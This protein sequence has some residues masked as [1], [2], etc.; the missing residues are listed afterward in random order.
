MIF[1]R[2]VAKL[3]AQDWVAI[4]I[5]LAIVIIGVF[6]G[7][8]AANWNQSRAEKREAERLLGELKP[9]LHNFVNYFDTAKPYYETTR[10]YADVAFGGWRRDP[11]VSDKQFVIAAYQASQIYVLGLNG[12]SWTAIFGSERLPNIDDGEV[13]DELASLMTLNYQSIEAEL[14]TVYREHVRQV[15]PE[16][17]QDAIR[18]HCGDRPIPNQPLNVQLPASCDLDLQPARFAAAAAELRTRPELAGDL[19]WHQSS[20]AGFLADMGAVEALTR[21]LL[22]RIE[23]KSA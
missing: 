16:D 21:D 3:R 15:I 11:S 7:I 22:Y 18:S 17:I 4:A 10:R 13:R 1:K 9:A 19:R 23:H 5:E 12:S 2:A 14:S 8:Q 6:V 20:V